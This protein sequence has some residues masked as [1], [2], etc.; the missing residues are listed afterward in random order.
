MCVALS[1]PAL[2]EVDT[3]SGATKKPPGCSSGG[4]DCALVQINLAAQRPPA[5]KREGVRRRPLSGVPERGRPTNG[6]AP[7]HGGHQSPI[8]RRVSTERRYCP[9][10]RDTQPPRTWP[11]AAPAR[12]RGKC[13]ITCAHDDPERRWSCMTLP[14]GRAST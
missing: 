13:A 6:K 11:D 2:G 4:S 5:A 3:S 14:N 12:R 8:A 9:G 10:A 7:C 1:C